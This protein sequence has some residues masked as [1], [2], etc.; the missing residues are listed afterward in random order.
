MPWN[1]IGTVVLGLAKWIF[2]RRAKKKLSTEEFLAHI[3]HH[4][5]NRQNTGKSAQDF[6]KAMED[7]RAKLKDEQENNN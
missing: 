4:Q 1:L 6:D 2:E 3:E 5:K 7:A